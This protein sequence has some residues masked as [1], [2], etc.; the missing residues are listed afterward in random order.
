[1]NH[2]T[3]AQIPEEYR[4]IYR[5]NWRTIKPSVKHGRLRDMY[6]FPLLNTGNDAILE[7]AEETIGKYNGKLKVNVAFGF[8]LKDRL[9]DDLK[10][11]HPSNN[12]MVFT[13]PRLLETPS[14]YRRFVE[15]IEEEDAFEY[16]RQ[17]RPSTKWKVER[18]ICVRFD[19]YKLRIRP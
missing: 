15:E 6:H 18:I 13:N 16:A 19:I 1:M 5:R 8:I 11:Y 4:G 12:T 10:F 14:D 17:H 3:L 9:T 2:L 7:K